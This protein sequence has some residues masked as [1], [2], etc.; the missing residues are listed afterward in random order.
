M[1]PLFCIPK[2]VCHFIIGL[3]GCNR[4]INY[5]QYMGKGRRERRAME[6]CLY[7]AQAVG[8]KGTLFC[9]GEDVLVWKL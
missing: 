4:G 1:N 3:H 5:S 2:A 7:S 6:I 8:I 9:Y